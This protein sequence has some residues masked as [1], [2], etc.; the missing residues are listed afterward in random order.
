MFSSL[1]LTVSLAGGQPPEKIYYPDG[2]IPSTVPTVPAPAAYRL[3]PPKPLTELPEIPRINDTATPMPVPSSAP[4][5]VNGIPIGSG[6]PC[7]ECEPEEEAAE[8]YFLERTLAQTRLGNI[9]ENRGITIYGWTQFSQNLSTASGSNAPV[10]MIDRANEFL[11]NQNYLVVEKTLDT[12]K[13]ERQWGWRMDWILP[14]SDYRFTLPRGLWN[15]QLTRNNGGPDLYGIDPYQFYFQGYLPNIGEGTTVKVGRFATHCA[16]ELVQAVDTP[17]VSRAYMF[18]YNPFT[19]TGVW[20]VTQMN[21]AWSVGYGAATGSDTFI[22]PANRFTFLGN[23]RWAP[24]EGRTAIQFNTVISDADFNA[25][26]AFPF[27]NYYGIVA[28]HKITDKLTY[29]LDTAYSHVDDVP[30]TGFA[31]WYGAANYFI[32]GINDNL[33]TTLR[34]EVF[35]DP[36]GFRTGFE[37]MYTEATWGFAW[38]PVNSLI[39][40]PSVRYDY[41]GYSRPFEGDHHLWTGAFEA[42]VRW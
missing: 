5:A 1:L 4:P 6:E 40:R 41:N 29:A 35:D 15:D 37:G 21:D 34:A 13:K 26:E 30:N 17:F 18:Q 25:A 27:Y 36:Q 14:G 32:Y 7:A 9:L 23:L 8:K 28:T 2:V 39:L 16:Y 24:P 33:S 20:A 31:N 19:H 38:K 11:M 42:I 3:N 10:L 12:E 22:D